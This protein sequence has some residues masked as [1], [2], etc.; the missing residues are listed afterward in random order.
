M[1]KHDNRLSKKIRQ[2][3]RQEKLKGRIRAAKNAGK[4]PAP[5]RAAG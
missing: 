5:T 3:R 4:T 2:R 1:G